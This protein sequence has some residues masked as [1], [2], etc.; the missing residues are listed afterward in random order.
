M[1]SA[2]KSVKKNLRNVE[3]G[4][5]DGDGD[6]D[7]DGDRVTSSDNSAPADSGHQDRKQNTI[8]GGGT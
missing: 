2:S 3:K 5:S 7:G 4:D 1:K 8:V 6:G